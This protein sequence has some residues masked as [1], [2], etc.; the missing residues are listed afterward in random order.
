MLMVT[1]ECHDKHVPRPAPW[2]HWG[3]NSTCSGRRDLDEPIQ[4][5]Y[6]HG[7]RGGFLCLLSLGNRQAVNNVVACTYTS[8]M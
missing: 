3:R 2:C 1:G 5:L 4:S 7:A 8:C 6:R